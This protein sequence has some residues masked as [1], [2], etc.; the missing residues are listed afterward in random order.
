MAWIDLAKFKEGLRGFEN[1]VIDLA[2]VKEGLRGLEN[3][4]INIRFLKNLW[5]S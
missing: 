3:T 1:T 5:D 4:M 2:K